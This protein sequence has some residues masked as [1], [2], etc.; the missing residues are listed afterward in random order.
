MCL[1]ARSPRVVHALPIFVAF[2]PQRFEDHPQSPRGRRRPSGL[3]RV[4]LSD[5]VLN[6][7]Q[8][9]ERWRRGGD[10]FVV[11]NGWERYQ[12]DFER[13]A[14]EQVKTELFGIERIDCSVYTRVTINCLE[15]STTSA[16]NLLRALYNWGAS[17]GYDAYGRLKTRI[18]TL[19]LLNSG[20]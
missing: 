14:N 4:V 15:I 17:A 18:D 5:H 9:L 13:Y 11:G 7:Q 8:E 10:Y 19:G 2:L 12:W 16:T 3:F 1:A 6:C 20:A